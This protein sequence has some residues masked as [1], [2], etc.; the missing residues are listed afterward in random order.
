MGK[1]FSALAAAVGMLL[2]ILDGKTALIGA[3]EGIGLCIR[4]VVPSLFPFFVLSPVLVSS[5]SARW[6]KPLGRLCKLPE[7]TEALLLVGFLGGY[8]TGA[9]C[10]AQ[11]HQDGLLS[12]SQA[13]RM[14]AFCSNA[15]PSFLFGMIAPMFGD[16]RAPWL[17]WIIHIFSAVCVGIWMPGCET[18]SGKP[19]KLTPATFPQA[20]TGAVKT[21]AT[22]CGWVVLFRTLITFLN[23]WVLWM[24][25]P[26][27]QVI[28]KGLLELTNGCCALKEIQ[29]TGLRFIVCSGLLAFGGL[30]VTMQTASVITGFSLRPYLIGKLH[31]TLIS[32]LMA[33]FVQQ[34]FPDGIRF[35][36]LIFLFAAVF[37]VFF[38]IG[39]RKRKN[40]CSNP[41]P[42]GV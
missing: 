30:C 7:G 37:A 13:E 39:R 25:G 2:L 24:L 15:G 1:Q 19:V 10:V 6:L 17:L 33:C 40:N 16:A 3:Q 38:S 31:Q 20:L 23:R 41:Q 5:L 22:V 12:R 18:T 21:M 42:I 35:S 14:M 27:A 32:V 29:N 4:T 11:S 26:D 36:P 9:Q 8:P 28:V 34:F